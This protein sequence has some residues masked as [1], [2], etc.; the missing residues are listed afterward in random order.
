MVVKGI[1]VVV[2]LVE[3][4]ICAVMVVLVDVVGLVVVDAAG[5]VVVFVFVV[6]LVV[7]CLVVDRV[8]EVLIVIFVV[9]FKVWLLVD[10]VSL[11]AD[12]VVTV[13]V[14]MCCKQF[15]DSWQGPLESV[16][17]SPSTA[18]AHQGLPRW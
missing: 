4:G 1:V 6:V 16:F 12:T 7:V 18:V 17:P 15:W 10:L 11:V 13:A 3:A 8:L 9:E 2:L 5:L 14:E